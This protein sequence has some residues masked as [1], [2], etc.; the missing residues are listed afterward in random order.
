MRLACLRGNEVA[1]PCLRGNEVAVRFETFAAK[2]LRTFYPALNHRKQPN[3]CCLSGAAEFYNP[4][5]VHM[6]DGPAEFYTP[7]PRAMGRQSDT[8]GAGK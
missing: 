8:P 3:V 4:S 1:V 2:L 6:G 5:P 7:S